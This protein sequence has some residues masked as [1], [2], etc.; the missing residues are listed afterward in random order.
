MPV[1]VVAANPLFPSELDW[2]WNLLILLV[3]TFMVAALFDVMRLR[4][5]TLLKAVEWVALIVVL[6]IVGPSLWFLYGRTR[7]ID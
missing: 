5:A 6:P 7:F 3:T 4:R 2:A 1:E